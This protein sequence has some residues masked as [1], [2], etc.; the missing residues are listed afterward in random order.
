[1]K[2]LSVIKTMIML[3]S[4]VKCAENSDINVLI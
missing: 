2:S 4:H 1:M 3:S